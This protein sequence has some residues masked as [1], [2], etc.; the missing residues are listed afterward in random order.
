MKNFF[1]KNTVIGGAEILFRLP[2]IFTAGYLARSIGPDAYGNWAVV[3]VYYGLL[4][5]VAGLGLPVSISRLA[6]VVPPARAHAYLGVAFRSAGAA[7][8]A[9]SVL[10]LGIWPWLGD[11]LGVAPKFGHLFAFS[12]LLAVVA[13]AESLLD[14]Y[15]KAREE[16]VRVILFAGIRTTVEI[17]AVLATFYGR[18]NDGAQA[19][20]LLVT[21]IL[22]VVV[23]KA[24]VYPWLLAGKRPREH[25]SSPLPPV[26]RK[27]FLRYGL[28]MVPA[29]LVAWFVAQ[30]DRL[31]LTH[32]VDKA[33]LGVYAFS[34]SLAANMIYIGYAVYPLLLP[35]AAQ[36]YEAG[37]LEELKALFRRSQYLTALLLTM[38]ML[39]LAFFSREILLWTA[40]EKYIDGSLILLVLAFA[41]GLEQVLGVHQY[42]FHLVKRTRWIFWL[43]L[44]QGVTLFLAVWLSAAAGG[45]R[46]VP[47]GV[48]GSILISNAIRYAAASRFLHVPR[49]DFLLTLLAG[50]L[51]A[52]WAAAWAAE[53]MVLGV[54]IAV[55]AGLG[56]ALLALLSSARRKNVAA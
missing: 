48:L 17:A 31:I 14:A 3:I 13:V 54:R 7:L 9:A 12:L 45:A 34:A 30:G 2:L 8:L 15:F 52:A 24:L 55:A 19:G 53:S 36:L 6:A 5:N 46:W 20:S 27:E 10:T 37:N 47:W 50:V 23:L 56:G 25:E 42:I 38:A 21:Y 4:A 28:P 39:G 22:W 32:Q 18:G 49:P 51:A 35:R 16:I 33:S 11:L 29:A 1:R 41:I 40:G 26:V 44:Q 43:N